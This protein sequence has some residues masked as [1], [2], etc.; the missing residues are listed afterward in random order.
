MTPSEFAAF[1][2]FGHSPI[3]DLIAIIC[4][5]AAC[6]IISV[7]AMVSCK[8]LISNH[9]IHFAFKFMFYLSI[10]ASLFALLSGI[11]VVVICRYH[12]RASF[13][14]NYSVAFGYSVLN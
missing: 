12:I 14:A 13:F 2:C 9:D 1:D 6:F 11:T 7:V 10:A 8:H 4:G 5:S 3:D